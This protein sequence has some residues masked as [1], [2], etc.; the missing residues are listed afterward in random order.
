MVDRLLEDH[1]NARYLAEKLSKINEINIFT[2]QLDI[3]MVFFTV[4][5]TRF[6]EDSFINYLKK[7]GI[8]VNPS[9]NNE[10]RFVTHHH[11]NKEDIDYI[12]KA[13]RNFFN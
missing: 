5:K 11:I 1:K 9:E 10:F 7:H 13:I 2:E 3:N 8:K 12:V 6:D 4:N